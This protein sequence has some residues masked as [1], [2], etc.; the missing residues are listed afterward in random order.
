MRL[1]LVLILFFCYLV[2]FFNSYALL[3]ESGKEITEYYCDEMYPNCLLKGGKTIPKPV[4]INLKV[5]VI[6][7]DTILHHYHNKYTKET[8]R[9]SIILLQHKSNRLPRKPRACCIL[10]IKFIN[11]LNCV[12]AILLTSNPNMDCSSSIL[13]SNIMLQSMTPFS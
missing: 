10:N 3:I 6:T 13:T 11:C 2:F 9:I 12:A 1:Q 7:Y 8:S 5:I 4:Q